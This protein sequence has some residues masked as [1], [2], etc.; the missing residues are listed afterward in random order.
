MEKAASGSLKH[1]HSFVRTV[2][3]RKGVKVVRAIGDGA[4]DE[5][6]EGETGIKMSEVRHLLNQLH[7]HGVVDYVRE[8]NMTTGWFTYTWSFNLDRTMKNFLT[9]KRERRRQLL[10]TLGQEATTQFYSCRKKCARAA[11]DAA[12]EASFRCP[13]CNGK[14][15]FLDNAEV[16]AEIKEE[17]NALD[18]ILGR[19][20]G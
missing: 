8:K 5:K 12:A 6:I 2:A 4:T 14:M 17:L 9:V 20:R 11:F 13:K 15:N 10:E 3:G 18:Q 1:L 7:K 19:S 16:V